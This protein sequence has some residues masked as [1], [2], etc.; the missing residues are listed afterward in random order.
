MSWAVSSPCRTGI[1]DPRDN[2]TAQNLTFEVLCGMM[3]D[4]SDSS[5]TAP[6]EGLELARALVDEDVLP[7]RCLEDPATRLTARAPEGLRFPPAWG[8]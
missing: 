8:I 2:G 6:P 3:Q 5:F 4:E 7:R 1:R